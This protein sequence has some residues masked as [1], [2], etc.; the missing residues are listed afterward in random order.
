MCA[1]F[2]MSA[3]SSASASPIRQRSTAR[4]L[5]GQHVVN[6]ARCDAGC[7]SADAGA[8][9]PA[10]AAGAREGRAVG[11]TGPVR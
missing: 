10:G 7:A 8:P 4:C 2:V 9:R 1:A 5:G 6:Q 11:V 3:S